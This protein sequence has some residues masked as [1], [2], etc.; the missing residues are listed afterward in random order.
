MNVPDGEIEMEPDFNRIGTAGLDIGE[1]IDVI[2]EDSEQLYKDQDDEVASVRRHKT[3]VGTMGESSDMDSDDNKDDSESEPEPVIFKSKSMEHYV[4]TKGN[5][6]EDLVMNVD[7]R[8]YDFV[9][10]Q[11]NDDMEMSHEDDDIMLDDLV[12]TVGQ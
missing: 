1:E 10:N 3:T 5:H 6:I 7:H 4:N 12:V 11:L 8:D 2:S 9:D